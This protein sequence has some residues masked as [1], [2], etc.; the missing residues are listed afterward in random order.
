MIDQQTRSCHIMEIFH[1]RVI[2]GCLAEG[3]LN[4]MLSVLNGVLPAYS[5]QQATKAALKGRISPESGPDPFLPGLGNLRN[6]ITT[7]LCQVVE[8]L[9]WGKIV[10]LHRKIKLFPLPF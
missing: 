4:N 10:P 6:T 9:T 7:L 8:R 2:T 1:D 3:T 5:V